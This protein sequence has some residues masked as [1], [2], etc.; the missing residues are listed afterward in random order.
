MDELN[1]I[2]SQLTDPQTLTWAIRLSVATLM[3]GLI[4][5]ERG[6]S[7]Q[8]AGLRTNMVVSLASCLFTL[9]SIFGFPLKGNAQD[10]ARIAAQI[11]T[12]IGFLGTGVLIQTKNKARGLTT[13]SSIWLV[14][15]VGMGIG[16]GQYVTISFATLVTLIILRLLQ[17]V[18]RSLRESGDDDNGSDIG[19]NED[20]DDPEEEEL[21]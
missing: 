9:I 10:T 17:P 13:A 5:I 8:S 7:G 19:K 11:V 15:A 14:G 20:D 2:R 3:G 4:G 6:Q 18:S 12:G 1:L 21:R 16:V